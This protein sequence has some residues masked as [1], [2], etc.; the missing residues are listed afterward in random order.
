[1][2]GVGSSQLEEALALA[3]GAGAH[4]EHGRPR[5]LML[6]ANEDL[7][8]A[9]GQFEDGLAVAEQMLEE[10]TQ[11]GDESFVANA[12][13]WSGLFLHIM[14]KPQEAEGRFELAIARLTP[15][16]DVD[17]AARQPGSTRA[18]DPRL[19]CSEP[20]DPGLPE[21]ARVRAGQ[22]LAGAVARGTGIGQAL[23]SALGSMTLFL[24]RSDAETLSSRGLQ[25]GHRL[26]QRRVLA[27]GKITSKSSSGGW[28]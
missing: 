20:V 26:C 21:K 15:E 5:L 11:C 9:R 4:A 23:A 12:H 6:Q 25:P 3:G 13:F 16:L 7:L 22:A 1:M 8:N 24:L 17:F 27:G 2:G 18:T 28:R 19:F 10:A 14:G